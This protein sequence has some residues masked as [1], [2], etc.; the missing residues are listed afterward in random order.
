MKKTTLLFSALFLLGTGTAQAQITSL[1]SWGNTANPY[2]SLTISGNVLYGMTSFGGANNYGSIF[3]M[4]RDGSNYQTLWNF[5]DTGSISYNANGA[6]P[7]GSLLLA[8]HK[9]YGVTSAGGSGRYGNVFSINTNGTG[10]R[11]LWDFQDSGSAGNASG[12]FP[13]GSLVLV[14]STLFGCTANGGA[15]SFGTL[16]SIDTLGHHYRDLHDFSIASGASPF[17]GALAVSANGKILYGTTQ[18]GGVLAYGALFSIDTN[19]AHYHD[20]H[21]FNGGDGEY[22]YGSLIVSGAQLFGTT[23]SGGTGWGDGTVFTLDTGGYYF[24]NLLNFTGA[25]GA[26]PYGQVALLGSKL[27]GM[28]YAGGLYGDGV[29]FCLDTNGNGYKDMVDFNGLNGFQPY[30]N[31]SISGDTLYGM[32]YD[33]GNYMFGNIFSLVDTSLVTGVNTVSAG[34]AVLNIY[35]NP[36]NGKVIVNVANGSMAASFNDIQVYNSLGEQVYP[37]YHMGT[38]FTI[39][40]SLQPA[41][42][43]FVRVISNKGYLVGEGKV[44]IQK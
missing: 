25:T 9:F 11:D 4:N 34:S 21:D 41:G 10:Y 14:G 23:Q 22:P 17:Y 19:G 28:T 24:K 27:Y 18:H 42:V 37:S 5:D 6:T 44:I 29:I 35:P 36:S 32:T 1:Y 3:S 16:F 31:I 15:N 38:R 13:R 2:G 20:I 7:Q 33:G 8:G 39:D 12:D 40:L 30:G 26:R 43:Y